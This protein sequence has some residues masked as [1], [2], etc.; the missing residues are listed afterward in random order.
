M[1][2]ATANETV[3]PGCGLKMAK[4]SRPTL[5]KYFNSSPECWSVCTEVFE[6]EYS[7]PLLFA[8]VHQLTVDTYAVQ[9][10]GGQH[11]DKSVAIHL[12][13]LHLIWDRGIHPTAIPSIHQRL[14]RMVR[15]WPHFAPP[16][17]ITSFTVFDIP[18][19]DSHATAVKEWSRIVWKAWSAHHAAIGQFVG[20]HLPDLR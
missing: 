1:G 18:L 20:E 3:C 5:H 9:H 14:A 17:S 2:T 13:G 19:S 12:S 4:T 11:P 7:N 15:S 16:E 8:Q 10:A 6:A